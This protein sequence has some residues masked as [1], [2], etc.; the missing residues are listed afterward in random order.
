MANHE[1][2]PQRK[3]ASA[4][5][6]DVSL[7]AAVEVDSDAQDSP[8]SPAQAVHEL[9]DSVSRAWSEARSS[10]SGL[11]VKLGRRARNVG[12][13][14]RAAAADTRESFDA[15]VGEMGELGEEIAEDA[16]ELGRAVGVSVSQFVRRHPI[17]SIA[18][19]VENTTAAESRIRDVDFASET[20][21]LTRNQVLQQAGISVLA[22]ANVSTQSALNLLQG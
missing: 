19:A 15:A 11:G 12:E 6:D 14:T 3:T 22:Q 21:E 4:A 2:S 5:T 17:R 8:T 18:I 7:D 9:R 16:M 13:E 20:A 1:K 10:V